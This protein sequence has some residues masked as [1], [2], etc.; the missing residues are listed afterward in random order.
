MKSTYY[1]IAT[2][3]TIIMLV[4]GTHTNGQA[5]G[6]SDQ[7]LTPI[8]YTT[9]SGSTG[10]QPVNA[11]AVK[12]QSGKDNNANAY[13]LFT[14]PGVAYEGIQVFTL[15]TNSQKTA[16]NTMLLNINFMTT[17]A[18]GQR[19]SWSI[20]NWANQDWTLLGTSDKAT[21]KGWN[22][23][24]FAAA[25]PDQFVDASGEIR[26]RLHS[27][28]ASGDAKIDYEAIYLT[29]QSDATATSLPPTPTATSV[30]PTPTPTA[31]SLPPTPTITPVPT[32][33][34]GGNTFYVATNGNDGNPGTVSQPWR[35]VKISLLKLSSGD[36]LIF[37][38]GDFHLGGDIFIGV[39]NGFKN[40]TVS[41]P[42]T[43]TAYAN[44]TPVIFTGNTTGEG[45][46]YLR[47][48]QYW[49][50][51]GL[52]IRPYSKDSMYLGSIDGMS[53]DVGTYAPSYIT[54]K[55]CSFVNGNH[56][57][58]DIRNGNDIM[59]ENNHFFNI[60]PR[61]SFSLI[62]D[63]VVAIDV[64][65]TGN[66]IVIKNN[67]FE[68]IGS[69]GVQL[70][71][72]WYTAQSSG[73][74][75]IQSVVI[76]NNE[77]RINRDANGTSIYRDINGNIA[78][79]PGLGNTGE[80]AIDVKKVIGPITISGNTMHGF[81]ASKA[82]RSQDCS[83]SYGDAVIIHDNAQNIIVET[84]YFY[85]NT[86]HLSITKG[87][88]GVDWET[89]NITVRN[90]IFHK[91]V[92]FTGDSIGSGDIRSGTNLFLDM[93]KDIKIYNNTFIGTNK[94]NI[95]SNGAGQIGESIDYINNIIIGGTDRFGSDVQ[96]WNSKYNL[97][98]DVSG[99]K[100]S[101]GFADIVSLNPQI[102]LSTYKPLTGSP[103]IDA[104]VAVPVTNDYDG[105]PRPL[106]GGYDIGAYEI[107]IP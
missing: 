16:L 7:N 86:I 44:E 37:R 67:L 15:P 48:I 45:S 46:L 34:P 47:D 88:D 69:D 73:L 84:N 57:A 94:F 19:W 61:Q 51:D 64:R 22:M 2:F 93:V 26:V 99:T 95:N 80:N 70:G 29:Y 8:S 39:G 35:S 28:D 75:L 63:E 104:G 87:S 13:V 36:T 85:D 66:N 78:S 103:A 30:P 24:V 76:E 58:I 53:G 11:L 82:D 79:D 105:N 65:R 38:G 83:G 97:W 17:G 77:F 10:G 68:D 106:G 9:T 5:S 71:S 6:S 14:T 56:Q 43:L 18:S 59:I 20:Y 92:P 42:I 40:G 96:I 81:R 50:F 107:S 72:L 1:R 102:D 41:S 100:P 49:N 54:I 21:A 62:G 31:T 98:S 4:L 60:R 91:T 12:D 89:K 74:P 101:P 90:N 3:I 55:N 25:S 52:T 32:Q 33:G 27:S 23:L